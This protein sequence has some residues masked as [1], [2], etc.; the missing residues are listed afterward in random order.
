[1]N[2]IEVFYGDDWTYIYCN[3]NL[4]DHQSSFHEAHM[5]DLLERLQP[6]NHK[7]YYLISEHCS[8]KNWHGEPK[9]VEKMMEFAKQ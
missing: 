4:I 9:T 8:H 1:M 7:T 2:K 3:G 6:F 5:L